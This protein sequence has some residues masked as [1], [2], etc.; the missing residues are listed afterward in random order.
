MQV[1][2]YGVAPDP[3]VLATLGILLLAAGRASWALV[4]IPILW[5]ALSGAV[6]W[7]ME[8]PDALVMPLAGVAVLFL[9]GTRK[10]E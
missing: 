10:P 6:Q 5:C 1:E 4:V 8:S 7:T 2:I 3:T 9:A